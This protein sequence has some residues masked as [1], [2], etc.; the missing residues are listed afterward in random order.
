MKLG[1]TDDELAQSV[2]ET[3]KW[4]VH[5]DSGAIVVKAD[6][7]DVTLTGDVASDAER[8]R[9]ISMASRAG[10]MNVDASGLNVG[11]WERSE[12]YR[13]VRPVN[14]RPQDIRDAIEHAIDIDPR[15][16]SDDI[17]VEV[18]NRRVRLTGTVESL[19]AKAAAGGDAKSTH[20]VSIVVNHIRVV[21]GAE[22]APDEIRRSVKRAFERGPV[23][24]EKEI[25][26]S[27]DNS[28]RVTLRGTVESSTVRTNAEAAAAN[29]NGVTDVRNLLI[30]GEPDLGKAGAR[31]YVD[32]AAYDF[33]DNSPKLTEQ[34]T[35]SKTD[36]QLLEDVVSE[37]F[38]SP[39]V[40]VDDISI[41]VQ[42]GVVTVS[43][44]VDDASDARDVVEN[45]Y[46]GGAVRVVSY[47][48][49]KGDD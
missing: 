30:V 11:D 38:W 46:E 36:E 14:L 47:L 12:M 49:I 27:V 22:R 23:I 48:E 24:D 15:V 3:L 8:R 25:V 1:Q 21:P 17:G 44:D 4:D 32:V 20:G 19:G 43:G 5:I 35:T 31:P 13:D 16:V 7:T 9:A 6:G 37:M 41:T 39:F 26:V 33:S 45:A 28:G 2:K 29:V 34:Y 10:A 18:G 42:D 40:D